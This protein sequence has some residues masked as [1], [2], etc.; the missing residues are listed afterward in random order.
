MRSGSQLDNVVADIDQVLVADSFQNVIQ[1]ISR[2]PHF[3]KD[4]AL[5][6]DIISRRKSTVE[7]QCSK[8]E[9]TTFMG[10]IGAERNEKK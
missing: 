7:L 1:T 8:T 6:D 9:W 2:N 3:H 10:A 5:R 4:H